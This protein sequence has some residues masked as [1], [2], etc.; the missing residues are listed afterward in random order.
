MTLIGLILIAVGGYMWKDAFEYRDMKCF[1]IGFLVA[2]VGT[3]LLSA[4]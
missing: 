2:A 4:V 3:G 1:Y